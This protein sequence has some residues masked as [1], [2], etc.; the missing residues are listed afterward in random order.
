[1][2]FWILGCAIILSIFG[3]IFLYKIAMNEKPTGIN[4]QPKDAE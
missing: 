1:M 2:V 4:A 3:F